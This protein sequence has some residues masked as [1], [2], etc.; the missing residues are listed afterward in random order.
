MELRQEVNMLR[1]RLGLP[2]LSPRPQPVPLPPIIDVTQ[3]VDHGSEQT[4]RKSSISSPPPRDCKTGTC[5]EAFKSD[6]EEMI[7]TDEENESEGATITSKAS[8]DNLNQNITFSMDIPQSNSIN[9]CS[10]E[11]YNGF[12]FRDASFVP[13]P[14]DYTRTLFLQ[15]QSGTPSYANSDLGLD[16]SSDAISNMGE[17]HS[18]GQF[19]ELA[20]TSEVNYNGLETNLSLMSSMPQY[21]NDQN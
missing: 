21:E 4:S 8:E 11:N 2:L 6:L 15:D 7:S 16:L 12:D 14:N 5:Y 17:L 3:D 19:E 10:I 1:E 13:T 20:L 9:H 18:M